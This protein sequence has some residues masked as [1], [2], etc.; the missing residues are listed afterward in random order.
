MQQRDRR[1]SQVM[2]PE[3]IGLTTILVFLLGVVIGG[4]ISF[5]IVFDHFKNGM[6]E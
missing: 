5:V 6:D 2:T 1:E 4:V 3:G